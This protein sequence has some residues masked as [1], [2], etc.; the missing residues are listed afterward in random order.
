MIFPVRGDGR[1]SALLA[2]AHTFLLDRFRTHLKLYL[3]LCG[4]LTLANLFTGAGW[5]SFTPV[6]GW[7]MA[8]AVHYFYVRAANVDDDWVRDRTED[9]AIRSYDLGH[10][11]DIKGRIE[12]G[13]ESV[14][15]RSE[16]A[17]GGSRLR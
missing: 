16:R 6:C 13:D 8:V 12:R 1:W 11:T 3:V 14:H 17:G 10:V 15:P 2:R 5:W 7:G 9:L 4:G